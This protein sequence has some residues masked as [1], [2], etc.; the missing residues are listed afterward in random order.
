[1]R[2]HNIGCRK[3]RS[4]VLDLDQ[5]VAAERGGLEALH[6]EPVERPVIGPGDEKRSQN[7]RL[8]G[9]GGDRDK[10]GVRDLRTVN[11]DPDVAVVS[12]H[13]QDFVAW[14]DRAC[15]GALSQNRRFSGNWNLKIRGGCQK[16]ESVARLL[17]NQRLEI[18]PWRGLRAV[19]ASRLRLSMHRVK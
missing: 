13:Q 11:V 10:S 9:R 5:G 15:L 1:I 19:A 6:L 14:R 18:V 4:S 2:K 3:S 17:L 7:W 16:R 8:P 12:A